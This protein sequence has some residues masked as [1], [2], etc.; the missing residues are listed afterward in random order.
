MP[1]SEGVAETAPGTVGRG[2]ATPEALDRETSSPNPQRPDDATLTA[3]V[4]E[5]LAGHPSVDA[6]RI[7]ISSRD[8]IVT[9]RGTVAN[10]RLRRLIEDAVAAVPDVDDVANELAIWTGERPRDRA[11][12]SES[13]AVS[14][15]RP[16]DGPGTRGAET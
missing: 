4:R 12:Q 2:I 14:P 15:D 6:S 1:G 10:A 7:E 3:R 5:R 9:L 13:R 16:E 8:G 11:A